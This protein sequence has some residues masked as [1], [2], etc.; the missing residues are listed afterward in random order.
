MP[1]LNNIKTY[2]FHRNL[3]EASIAR[4]S[5]GRIE[6]DN[7]GDMIAADYTL[8][9]YQRNRLIPVGRWSAGPDPVEMYP[10]QSIIWPGGARKKPDGFEIPTHLRVSDYDEP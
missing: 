8:L 1:K 2:N 7:N 5:T 6:F 4:G 3:I 9:N 10:K